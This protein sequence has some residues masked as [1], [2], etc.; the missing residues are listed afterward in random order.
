MGIAEAARLMDLLLRDPSS[1]TGAAAAGLAEPVGLEAR[2]MAD[3]WDLVMKAVA[4]KKAVA[5]K[6]PWA[7]EK[8]PRTRVVKPATRMTVNDFNARWAEL[9]RG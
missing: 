6:R 4:G 8:K 3:L 5:Y 7:P 9:T 1:A 2:V